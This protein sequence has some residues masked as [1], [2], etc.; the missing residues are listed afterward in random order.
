MIRLVR[1]PSLWASFLARFVFAI[2]WTGAFFGMTVAVWRRHPDT[3]VLVVLGCFDL[4]AIAILW[5]LVVRFWRTLKHQEPF[6]EIDR[7]SLAY[8]DSAQVR[9]VESHPES[10]SEMGVKLVG[11]C[12]AK[13]ATDISSYRETKTVLTRCYDEELLRL[14]PDASEPLSRLIRVQLPKSPPADGITWK[15]IVDS[16]LKQGGV[17]EHAYPIRVRE[18]A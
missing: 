14:K 15:I 8:G 16:H 5:D 18:N 11:E 2:V 12:Y 3:I 7:Q 6:V 9:I 17:I 1:K 10:I 13:S 4:I